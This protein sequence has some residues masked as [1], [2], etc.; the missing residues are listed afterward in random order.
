MSAA[1]MLV[2]DMDFSFMFDVDK[3]DQPFSQC[4]T[5]GGS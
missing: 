3:D 4:I 1:C 5:T 2:V